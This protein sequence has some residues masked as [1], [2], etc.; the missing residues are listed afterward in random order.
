MQVVEFFF[1]LGDNFKLIGQV[2][3]D[4]SRFTGAGFCFF[5]FALSSSLR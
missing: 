4:Q 2:F 1:F 5:D 3:A